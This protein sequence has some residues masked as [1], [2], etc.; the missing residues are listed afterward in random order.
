M[1]AKVFV[2]GKLDNLASG[3]IVI[4]DNNAGAEP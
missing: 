4:V 3:T 2:I 1:Y